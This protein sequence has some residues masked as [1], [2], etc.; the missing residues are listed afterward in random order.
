MFQC[1]QGRKFWMRDNHPF[2]LINGV[3]QNCWIDSGCLTVRNVLLRGPRHGLLRLAAAGGRGRLRSEAC[4]E[5]GSRSRPPAKP[6]L[7][8]RAAEI[9]APT[10]SANCRLCIN[11]AVNAH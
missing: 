5:W 11:L 4:D 7:L 2:D 1:Q 9:R 8:L 3:L 6:G 10:V